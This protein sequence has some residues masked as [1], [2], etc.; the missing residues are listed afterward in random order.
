MVEGVVLMRASAPT[1]APDPVPPPIRAAAL[2][3]RQL[4]FHGDARSLGISPDGKT[5]TF[6]LRQGV[7]WHDGKPFTAAD[8]ACTFDL[9]VDPPA[10]TVEDDGGQAAQAT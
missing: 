6:K 3:Q 2:P 10:R 4:T 7:T 1:L 8:V 5:V 9:P